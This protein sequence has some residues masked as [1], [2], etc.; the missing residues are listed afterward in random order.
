M[1]VSELNM[2]LSRFVVE[3]RRKDGK[4]YPPDTLH[5]LCCGVLRRLHEYNQTIDIFKNPEFD[6]F[7]KTLDAE[8]KCLKR[9]S[10]VPSVMTPSVIRLH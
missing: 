3:I 2:L 1:Q 4:H 7:R 5:Q 8:M 10:K 6:G 9:S